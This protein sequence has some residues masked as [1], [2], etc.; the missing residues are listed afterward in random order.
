MPGKRYRLALASGIHGCHQQAP[1]VLLVLTLG[2]LLCRD[3]RADTLTAAMKTQDPR[4]Q[5]RVTI[6][7][8]RILVGELLERLSKQSGVTVTA[9]DWSAAGCDDVAVSFVNVPLSQVMDAL[10]SLFSYQNAEWEWRRNGSG[11][12]YS[13]EL[14]RPSTAQELPQKWQEEAQ[15]EFVA[16]TQEVVDALDMTPDQL[17]KASANDLALQGLQEGDGIERP[18]MEV[19]ASLPPDVQQNILGGDT[20]YSVSVADLS[21]DLQNGLQQ[22]CDALKQQFVKQFGFPAGTHGYASIDMPTQVRIERDNDNSLIAPGLYIDMGEQTNDV[23]GGYDL[24]A[25]LKKQFHDLWMLPGDAGDDPA[26][27]RTP[28]PAFTPPFVTPQGHYMG[29]HL[30]QEAD[31]V[32]VPL[33]ARIPALEGGNPVL[34]TKGALAAFL[35]DADG[36]AYEWDH[37]WRGGVLL[38]TQSRWFMDQKEEA[39]FPWAEA[40]RLRDAEA[41]SPDGLVPLADLEHA[42]HALTAAQMHGL[43][44]WFPVLGMAADWHDFL[45]Y[46]DQSSEYLPHLM[47]AQGDTFEYPQE[48]VSDQLGIGPELEQG[49]N[50]RLRMKAR[51]MAFPGQA[52]IHDELIEVEALNDG[53]GK[54]VSGQ[55]F[56]YP[57]HE[58]ASQ[59]QVYEPASMPMAAPF[60]LN[61]NLISP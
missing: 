27:A 17:K 55:G 45:S 37:K 11:G 50:L 16:Q 3:A 51:E 10:W 29:L 49:V 14:I 35:K 43:S 39:R 48:L 47:S 1:V 15:A 34:S 22:M 12:A 26:A 54:V 24:Q 46:L 40:A 8:P 7:S 57:N 44:E 20:A 6:Q 9:S 32:H 42:A 38:M 58:Y 52:G 33:L 18:G 13:Y 59:L 30:V 41:K 61:G 4:L 19:F 28:T 56:G 25:A 36:Q 23:C 53:D 31:A 5:A 2:L 21:P 60:I